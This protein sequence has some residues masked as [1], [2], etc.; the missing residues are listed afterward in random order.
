LLRLILTGHSRLHIPSETWFLE[1]LVD[2]LPLTGVLTAAQCQVAVATMVRHERWPDMGLSAEDMRQRAA[3]LHQPSLTDVIGIVYQHLLAASS[4]QRLGEK[5]PHYFAIVPQLATLFPDAKF[6]HLIRDGH[7][8]AMSW[9]DAGWERY[10]ES[11]FAWPAAMAHR[12]RQSTQYP[13]RILEVRYEDLVR[14]PETVTTDICTFLGEA[15]EP[16]MLHWQSRMELVATRDRHLHGH[17]PQPLSEE[18]VAV[19]RRR[20]RAPECFAME[21]CLHRELLEAGYPLRFAAPRWRPLFRLTAGV[22]RIL[23]PILRRGI[24]YLQRRGV[25][26]GEVYL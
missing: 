12:L 10:Y 3:L 16:G 17:L 6:I 13:G 26:P 19:W 5:T 9:I 11:G 1:P 21:A 4:K 22:L 24:P 23:A 2:A 18:A 15:F 8:V 25:L 7:D 20:L 14:R